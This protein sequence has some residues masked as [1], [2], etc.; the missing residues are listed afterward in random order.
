MTDKPKDI[1]IDIVRVR[2]VGETLVVTLTK[3]ILD[4]FPVQPGERLDISATATGVYIRRLS[5]RVD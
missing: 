4:E 5:D 3:P 2:K 1:P